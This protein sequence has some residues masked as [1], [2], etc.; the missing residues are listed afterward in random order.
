MG[1]QNPMLKQ[2][3]SSISVTVPL[4]IQDITGITYI[5]IISTTLESNETHPP[6][7]EHRHIPVLIQK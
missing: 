6:T 1:H 5:K 4:H 3:L 7:H 2:I